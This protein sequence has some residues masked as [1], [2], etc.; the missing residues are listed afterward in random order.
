MLTNLQ[1][2]VVL[3]MLIDAKRKERKNHTP[4]VINPQT[5]HKK[6]GGGGAI[7]E[8]NTKKKKSGRFSLVKYVPPLC[9]LVE[10]VLP[11]YSFDRYTIRSIL[12]KVKNSF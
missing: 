2:S 9:V 6:D 11:L 10:C 1:G 4:A 3:S 7:R 12:L 8:Q 5:T